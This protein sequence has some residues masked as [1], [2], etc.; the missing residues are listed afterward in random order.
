[1]RRSMRKYIFYFFLF[2][3]LLLIDNGFLFACADMSNNNKTSE[4]Y[5]EFSFN[6]DIAV[7]Y[8]ITALEEYNSKH[9]GRNLNKYNLSDPILNAI[10]SYDSTKQRHENVVFVAFRS[11]D[12]TSFACAT[13]IMNKDGYLRIDGRGYALEIKH[14]IWQ[15]KTPGEADI[16]ENF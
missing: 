15:L 4:T 2:G 6:R 3:I 10:I 14:I 9:S 16:W 5:T 7:K 13:L 8:A 1:M 11:H 12:G